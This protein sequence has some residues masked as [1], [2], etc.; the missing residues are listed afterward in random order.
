MV[1]RAKEG[2]LEA[3]AYCDGAEEVLQDCRVR[4]HLGLDRIERDITLGY[5]HGR[6]RGFRR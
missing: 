4:R 2:E 6:R 5:G 3:G 1:R